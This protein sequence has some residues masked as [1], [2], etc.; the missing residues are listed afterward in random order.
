[1]G[2]GRRRATIAGIDINADSTVISYID[3]RRGQ[4]SVIAAPARSNTVHGGY[5]RTI[6]HN[7]NR[8]I[9]SQ[10]NHLT[11]IALG[12]SSGVEIQARKEDEIRRVSAY[13]FGESDEKPALVGQECFDRTLKAARK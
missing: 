9:L 5:Q 11:Q 10:K 7:K 2:Q 13:L 12:E 4:L 6:V 3:D 1:L 8:K